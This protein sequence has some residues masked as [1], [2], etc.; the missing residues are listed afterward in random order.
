VKTPIS[1][2]VFLLLA[3]VG[4]ASADLPRK[5][6]NTKYNNLWTNSP[7]TSKPPPPEAGPE[8]NPLDDYALIGVSSLGS[9][10]YR[11]TLIN[12]KK[13]DEPR[14]YVETNRDSKGFKIIKVTRKEGDP[15]GT[16]VT[17]QSGTMTGTVSYEEKLLT[18]AAAAPKAAPQPVPGGP[19]LIPGQQ[20]PVPGAPQRQPR[21]RVVPPP[22][23]AVGGQP[24]PGQVLPGQ[25]QPGVQQGQP[26][27]PAQQ[28]RG[29]PV[30]RPE[31]R[32]N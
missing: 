3:L 24:Q 20:Q 31:R 15:L 6:P 25:I 4:V 29:N 10:N 1:Y 18:L 32:G 11:V 14:I 30:V 2:P 13:P 23:P 19:Q 16:V 7:F 22:A 21:P 9:K 8:N 5:A 26:V 17:M 27:P 12:K 28:N